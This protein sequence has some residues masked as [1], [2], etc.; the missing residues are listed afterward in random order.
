MAPMAV[1]SEEVAGS[2][3]NDSPLAVLFSK[4]KTFHNYFK[5]LSA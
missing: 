1:N 5:Q 4:N 3:D 2:M